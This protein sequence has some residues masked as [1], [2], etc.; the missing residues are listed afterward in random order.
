[1]SRDSK[2]IGEEHL[3]AF[4]AGEANEQLVREIEHWLS[5]S[6]ENKALLN[7]LE[8]A[9]VESGKLKISP[10][11]VDVDAAWNKLSAKMDA[12]E[13]PVVEL[14]SE[15]RSVSRFTQTFIRI[16]AVV[17]LAV[18]LWAIRNA[19]LKPEIQMFVS[20][21]TVEEIDLSDGSVVSM[22]ENT[23]IRVAEK[24]TDKTR[25]L[26]LKGEAFFE[27][28]PDKDKPFIIRAEEAYIRVLGTSFN[29]KAHEAAKEVE[30]YVEEGMVMLY[31]IDEL[32]SDTSSVILN[33]GETGVYDRVSG[34]VLKMGRTDARVLYWLNKTLIFEETELSKVFELLEIVYE[35]SIVCE[36]STVYNCR[37]DATFK[38]EKIDYILEVV[39]ITFGLEVELKDDATY[40]I[41]GEGCKF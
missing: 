13:K 40:Y 19:I 8:A 12:E 10:V 14:G 22:N 6:D 1:M 7:E 41:K 27:I 36:D 34:E 25:E 38:D 28:E 31:A 11:V 29:V 4:L 32:S 5:L 23:R 16:A 20:E 9:W 24:F 39:A 26:E 18:G 15:R 37:L 33:M 3:M 2:H 35:T 30:V 17:V 21:D